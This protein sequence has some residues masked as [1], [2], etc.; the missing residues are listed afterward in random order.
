MRVISGTAR[1]TKL[2]TVSGIDLVRPTTD[3]VKGAVFNM[4]QFSVTGGSVLDLFCGSGALGI[5]ALSRG[6]ERATFVDRSA[7]SLHITQENL[8]RTHLEERAFLKKSDW[9]EFLI[10]SGGRYSLVFADPPYAMKILPQLLSL[11]AE[12]I[13][14]D[15]FLIYECDRETEPV[16]NDTFSLYRHNV[17]GSTAVL[18][19]QRRS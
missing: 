8:E 11:C 7:C 10:R 5:E 13:V 19:Y 3:K 2:K 9:E 16:Q 12:R 4:V 14:P 6:A 1:G 17:Y 15:G 18:I